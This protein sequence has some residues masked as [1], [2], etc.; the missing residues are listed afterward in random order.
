MTE[1]MDTQNNP[2]QTKTGIRGSA[3]FIEL[4]LSRGVFA[5]GGQLSGSV[6]FRLSRETN[7]RALTVSVAGFETVA[8]ASFARVI[9]RQEPFFQREVLLSGREQ[10]RFTS[11]RISQFWNGFLGRDVGRTLSAGEHMYP[12]AIPLPVSLPSSYEGKAGRIDYTVTARVQFPIGSGVQVSTL[13]PVVFAPKGLKDRPVVLNYPGVNGAGEH[14][15]LGISVELPQ[16]VV[17][18]GQRTSGHF[19]VT[20]P[21]RTRIDAIDVL[22]ESCEWV[23]ES[24]QRELDRRVVESMTINPDD[25]CAEVIKGSFDLR[26]PSNALPTVEGTAISVLWFLKLRLNSEPPL[27]FKTPITVYLPPWEARRV[28]EPPI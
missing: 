20:N 4:H 1:V 13:V 18:S 6:V 3:P 25:P 19:I 10:P 17:E 27:E 15:D 8:G 11:E 28:T 14:A 21:H 22:L 23:R 12:F 16:R 5:T 26:V 9:R 7:I 2:L 24:E